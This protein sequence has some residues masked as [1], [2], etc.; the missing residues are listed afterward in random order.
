M[1]SLLFS[2]NREF[3]EL[4][5]RK[6]KLDLKREKEIDMMVSKFESMFNQFDTMKSDITS[7]KAG[8]E[9]SVSI[10]RHILGSIRDEVKINR[11]EFDKEL[12]D[13]LNQL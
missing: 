7:Q 11:S 5:N 1:L 13:I 9:K 2:K 6:H 10:L 8:I 12:S 4:I 3:L